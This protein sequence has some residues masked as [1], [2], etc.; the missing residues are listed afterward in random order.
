MSLAARRLNCSPT[1]VDAYVKRYPQVAQA[2]YDARRG[3]VDLAEAKLHAAVLKGEP[4]AIALVLKTLGRER[5][6][7]EPKDE[8]PIIPMGVPVIREVIVELPA[9][10][11]PAADDGADADG[12]DGAGVYD[13]DGTVVIEGQVR[14]S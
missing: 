7:A 10:P 2:L 11:E 6:F 12:A 1:T 13:Q 8:R 14:V 9:L 5:G 4:W 3:L